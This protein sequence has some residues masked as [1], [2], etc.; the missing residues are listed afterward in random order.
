MVILCIFC[1]DLLHKFY[2]MNSLYIKCLFPIFFSLNLFF[3]PS[4]FASD[5]DIKPAVY[6]SE[7]LNEVEIST[8]QSSEAFKNFIQVINDEDLIKGKVYYFIASAKKGNA[9]DRLLL[10]LLKDE[11]VL[12][13]HPNQEKI[14][15]L[16][17]PEYDIKSL[18]KNAELSE[19]KLIP[20]SKEVFFGKEESK[21]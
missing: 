7:P 9:F 6:S 4:V 11:L 16:V 19:I 2:N 1:V 20:I 15:I 5:N 21:N 14:A 18:I 3:L 8:L 13:L 17:K 10:G 12:K